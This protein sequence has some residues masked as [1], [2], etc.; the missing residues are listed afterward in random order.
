MLKLCEKVCYNDIGVML[1]ALKFDGQAYYLDEL[2][3]LTKVTD[4]GNESAHIHHFVELVYILRG[5]SLQVVDGV[6]YPVARGNLILINESQQ[7]SMTCQPGTDYMN[8]LMKPQ[9][10]HSSITGNAFSLLRLKDF[11][12]FKAG[13]RESNCCIHFAGNERNR[14]EMLLQWLLQEQKEG[15]SGNELMLRSGLN[16]LLI[17]VFRK[18]ALPMYCANG[19]I[20]SNLLEY[21]RVNCQQRISMEEV[22]QSCGYDPSYFSRLFK[23]TTGKTFTAYIASCRMQKACDLLE[24]TQLPVDTVIAE[25]GFSD[26]TKFFRQFNEKTGVTPLQYR[27]GK[28]QIL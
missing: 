5:K 7:H 13:V 8:I 1:M 27:K 19:G 18:M 15:G 4:A 24:N 11:A 20:D 3:T 25:C 6:E 22:A 12:A 10:I 2:A 26:R 9:I 17:Q 14:F 23:H 21:L 16:M 28:N